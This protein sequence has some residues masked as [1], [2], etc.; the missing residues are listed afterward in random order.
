M[1]V[2]IKDESP[3]ESTKLGPR[4]TKNIVYLLLFVL[5]VGMPSLL[6][7]GAGYVHLSRGLVA[8]WACAC[9]V[10]LAVLLGLARSLQRNTEGTPKRAGRLDAGAHNR[11]IRLI[12]IRKLW[13]VVLIALL[14]IG[15][16]YGLSQRAW[17]E[18][19][20]GATL[21]I[22]FAFLSY[23]EIKRMRRIVE[24]HSHDESPAAPSS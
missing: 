20:V 13:M 9:V 11:L 1:A 14:P 4:P 22:T 23:F 8:I 19:V 15:I 24:L 7:V 21:S 3:K 18:T 16:A 17:A 5:G 10:L 2:A 6:I 12:R